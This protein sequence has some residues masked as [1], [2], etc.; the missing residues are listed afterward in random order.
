MQHLRAAGGE[1][2]DLADEV[3]VDAVDEVFEVEVHVVRRAVELAGVVEAQVVGGEVVEI[4]PGADEGAFGLAHL[5]AVDGEEAVHEDL[6]G[7]LV[8]GTVEHRGPEEGVEAHDVFADEVVELGLGVL[9]VLREVVA[10]LRAPVLE[11]GHV[12][13][14]RV[15][16]DVEVFA[17]MA[18][19]FKAE[20]GRIAGDVPAAQGFV[21]PFE[22]LV[23]DVGRSVRGYP[24]LEEVAEGFELEEELFAV[25]LDGGLA[26]DG[27]GRV[28]QFV[29]AVRRRAGVARVAVLIARAAFGASAFDKA[30]GQ[31]HV[32]VFAVELLDGRGGD[33]TAALHRREDGVAECAVFVAV[34]S[35]VVVK[36]NLEVGKVFGVGGVA[37]LDD[38]L[39]RDA[40]LTRA[41]HDR[42]AVRIVGTDVN[43]LV[44]AHLLEPHPEVSL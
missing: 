7:R 20:V 30:V 13:D 17:G 35:V 40:F 6:V 24:L 33:I 42:R 5:L 22:E 2:G 12:A 4:S 31:E 10:V 21:E 15:H 3:G 43:A 18:G 28:F 38:R 32:V 23:G 25:A 44:A 36:R 9:P 34:G 8:A 27:A 41:D 29:R 19:D 14:G 26:A 16:P 1:V 11:R 37:L 39:W